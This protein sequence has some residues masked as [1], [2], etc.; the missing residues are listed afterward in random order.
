MLDTRYADCED[1]T[2]VCDQQF[3]VSH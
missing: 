3:P 1:V 2:L